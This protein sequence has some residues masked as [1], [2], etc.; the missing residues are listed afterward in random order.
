MILLDRYLKG[1]GN[2]VDLGTMTVHYL[3][4]PLRAPVSVVMVTILS[5]DTKMIVW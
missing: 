1:G 4:V 3:V 5:R 2:I